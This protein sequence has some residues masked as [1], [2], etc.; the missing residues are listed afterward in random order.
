MWP[1]PQETAHLVTFTEETVIGKL[2]FLWSAANIVLFSTSLI[3]DISRVSD[4]YIQRDIPNLNK[5]QQ[6]IAKQKPPK[7]F[8][9][10]YRCQHVL[11]KTSFCK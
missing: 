10:K 8:I 5:E 9:V 2:H 11:A 4:N 7:S 3:A 6:K 1:N